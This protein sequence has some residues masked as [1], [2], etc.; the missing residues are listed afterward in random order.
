M[1]QRFEPTSLSAPL[2]AKYLAFA[3]A[4]HGRLEPLLLDLIN[5][6]VSQLNGCAFCVDMHS[7]EA[8]LHGE[9]ELRLYHV[10][11]W[12]E[13]NLF[14]ARERAA[15]AWAEVLTNLPPEGVEDRLY[16]QVRDEFSEQEVS[17]LT[18]AV[19]AINGWNRANAA[20]RREPGS[21]DTM[22]GLAEAGLS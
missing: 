6:R 1:T 11:I 18:F 14:T 20:V 8:K 21:L 4:L 9:R 22:L 16:E 15:L 17:N 7:K 10:P 12:R 5:I 2:Y 13:S 3:E 19:I